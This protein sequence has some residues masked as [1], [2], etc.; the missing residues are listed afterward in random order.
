MY[1]TLGV[2][3]KSLPY[4]AAIASYTSIRVLSYWRSVITNFNRDN[5]LTNEPPIT[6]EEGCRGKDRAYIKRCQN[7][8]NSVE[9]IILTDQ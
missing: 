8:T 2:E 3:S 7:T 4:K 6:L 9:I 1:K 5:R